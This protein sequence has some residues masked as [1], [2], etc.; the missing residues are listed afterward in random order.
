[1]FESK[2]GSSW[3]NSNGCA[4]ISNTKPILSRVLTRISVDSETWIVEISFVMTAR[5]LVLKRGFGGGP[6]T[7]EQEIEKESNM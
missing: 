4:L 6:L 5:N 3:E 2:S 1:M 7:G